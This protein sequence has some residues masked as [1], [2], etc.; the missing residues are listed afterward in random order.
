MKD[1]E[2]RSN[3]EK[4]T[5]GRGGPADREAAIAAAL[6]D[7]LDRTSREELVD[8]GA[9]CRDYRGLEED[10]RP[11]L[12]A[13]TEM[14]APDH[15]TAGR[16]SDHQDPLPE[17]LSG[18]KILGEIGAG[19]MG[20][21]LLAQDEGLNRKIAIKVLSPRLSEEPVLCKK[22]ERWLRSAIRT[23]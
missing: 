10:L 21:V 15:S 12:Q 11:L 14:D 16:G 20:R 23:S 1:E 9:F 7:F 22:Q 13:L 2:T 5:V 17:R 4:E 6:A 8:V 19:G 3:P 18:H